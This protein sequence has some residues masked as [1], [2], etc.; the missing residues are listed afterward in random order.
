MGWI[1]LSSQHELTTFLFSIYKTCDSFLEGKDTNSC[2][3][4]SHSMFYLDS[5]SS[6]GI[7]PPFLLNLPNKKAVNRA[8]WP[9][10]KGAFFCLFKVPLLLKKKKKILL[11]TD[12]WN[13]TSVIY[14]N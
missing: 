8:G 1:F 14:C 10:T 9:P 4:V 2:Q 11:I 5:F 7:I 13:L 12:A 3:S 6:C